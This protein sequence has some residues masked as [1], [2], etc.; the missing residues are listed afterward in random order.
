MT[1]E[2]YYSECKYHSAHKFPEDG[3][4]CYEDQCR[5]DRETMKG[6]ESARRTKLRESTIKSKVSTELALNNENTLS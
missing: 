1:I 5:I 2:C 4:F 3:P 6:F